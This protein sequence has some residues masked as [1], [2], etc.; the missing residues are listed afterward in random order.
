MHPPHPP[1]GHPQPTAVSH[2]IHYTRRAGSR[3]ANAQPRPYPTSQ[4]R[5]SGSGPSAEGGA[6]ALQVA[7]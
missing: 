3:N 1:V 4:V 2:T 6:L 5:A 7:R